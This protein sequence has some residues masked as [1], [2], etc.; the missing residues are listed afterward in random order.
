RDQDRDHRGEDRAVDEE[1]DEARRAR[2]RV[3]LTVGG[4]R[5]RHG[6]LGP[7]SGCASPTPGRII[8]TS[9]GDRAA[10]GALAGSSANEGRV[11]RRRSRSARHERQQDRAD[12]PAAERARRDLDLSLHLLAQAGLELARERLD[13]LLREVEHAPLALLEALVRLLAVCGEPT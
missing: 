12:Q 1:R 8:P 3:L 10:A 6:L 11:E 7:A 4:V 9:R 13:L 5:R 2:A